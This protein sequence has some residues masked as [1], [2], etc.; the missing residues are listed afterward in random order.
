MTDKI[1][2]LKDAHRVVLLTLID[3]AQTPGFDHD[4]EFH[5]AEEAAVASGHGGYLH[6][7]GYLHNVV[8]GIN[9]GEI[10]AHSADPPFGSG[11]RWGSVRARIEGWVWAMYVIRRSTGR[12]L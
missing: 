3:R 6:A 1:E 2:T 11:T 9:R 4:R 5:A 7:V 10:D 12:G 8:D